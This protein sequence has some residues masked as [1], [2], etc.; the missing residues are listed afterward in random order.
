MEKSKNENVRTYYVVDGIVFFKRK[1]ALD[2][3]NGKR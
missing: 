1:D 3:I 2:Y